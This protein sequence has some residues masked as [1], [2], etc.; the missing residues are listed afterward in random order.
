MISIKHY[1]TQ[2]F[3]EDFEPL[4]S[5]FGDS[6]TD[7]S[8]WRPDISLARAQAG[9]VGSSKTLLYDFPD[10]KDNG[11]VVQTFIRSKALDVTEIDKAHKVVLDNL[12][13]KIS[14][15]SEQSEIK[16]RKKKVDDVLN[17]ALS[18]NE[19]ESP[20]IEQ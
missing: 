1:C 14:L 11:E 13:N 18:D 19:Q 7:T 9:S 2:F 5:D 15:D 4:L 12:E 6:N 10:G 3:N 8:T 20:K 17:K 16:K